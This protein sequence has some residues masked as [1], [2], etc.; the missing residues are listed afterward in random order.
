MAV[1]DQFLIYLHWTYP[2]PPPG[3]PPPLVGAV[4]VGLIISRE[5]DKHDRTDYELDF[6]KS[7]Q[8]NRSTGYE[9][10][11]RYALRKKGT[12][13]WGEFDDATLVPQRQM[14]PEALAP[15]GVWAEPRP[16]AEPE[17]LPP[18]ANCGHAA[19]SSGPFRGPDVTPGGVTDFTD[20]LLNVWTIERSAGR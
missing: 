11:I 20:L 12:C 14:V 2:P 7:I 15:D 19:S 8:T 17:P 18:T 3:Q 10:K 13:E 1:T 4:Y 6:S 5:D 16:P 9:R